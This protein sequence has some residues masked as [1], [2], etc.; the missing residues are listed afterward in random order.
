MNLK[1]LMLIE[2]HSK[3]TAE[4]NL[5]QWLPKVRWGIKDWMQIMHTEILRGDGNV[6]QL[7][8]GN[9]YKTIDLVKIINFN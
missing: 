5:G 6:L 3:M 7:D 4:Y 9:G 1:N 8:C 2:S